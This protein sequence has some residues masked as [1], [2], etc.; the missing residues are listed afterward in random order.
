[1]N[2]WTAI[3]IRSVLMPALLLTIL[4][5]DSSDSTCLAGDDEPRV[6]EL[7]DRIPYGRDPVDYFGMDLNDPVARLSERIEAREKTLVPD[8]RHG[9]LRSVLQLLNV[10]LSSQT[11]VFSRTARSPELVSPQTPR[12]VFFNDEVSVAWIPGARELELTAVDPVR[13]INFY[14]LSQPLDEP[15]GDSRS[16]IDELA[17]PRFQRRDRCL[18]C[19][20]GRSSLEVPGLL[21]RAFQTDRTGK[22]LTGFSRVTHAM[23]YEQRWGGWY[24]TGAPENVIHRGNLT[25]QSENEQHRKTPG[26]A[27]RLTNLAQKF[28]VA[29]YPYPQSD[30]V[31][32]LVLAHQVHGTN[33]LIRTSLESRLNRRSSVEDELIRYLVFA[34]EPPLELTPAEASAV[35]ADSEF[36]A[37]FTARGPTDQKGNSL[38][39]FSLSGHVFRN[40]LSF[41]IHSR[42]FDE[43]PEACREHLLIRLWNGLSGDSSNDDFAHLGRVERT[44][45][46]GIVRCTVPRLPACWQEQPLA[47]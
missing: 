23:T 42:L 1:M 27:S 14:T 11:L 2:S 37:Q 44:S 15:G 10:P 19:H 6:V 8:R 46:R 22:P 43:L 38:R 12:A 32:H 26:F 7:T 3:R 25:A 47:E 35:L 4:S 17:S 31:A 45:I 39:Q 34:D 30:F 13:G 33:L 36:A 9:Y 18:A 24:V 41:L 40:R 28:E 5:A 29:D 21:L 16:T 20:S